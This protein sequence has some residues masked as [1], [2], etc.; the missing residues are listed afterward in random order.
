V[1]P[2][3][4]KCFCGDCVEAAGTARRASNTFSMD[5][6]FVAATNEIAELRKENEQLRQMIAELTAKVKWYEEQFRLAQQYRFGASSERSDPDQPRL[7]NE[8]EVIADP[9]LPEPAVENIIYERRK[10]KGRREAMLANLPVETVE[11]RLSEE[12]QVCP[13]CGGPMHEMR[14]ETREELKVIPAQVKL[15]RHKRQVYAC[16]NCQ[17]NEERTP[18]ATA[19]MPNPV[20]KNSLASSSAVAYIMDQKYGNGMPLYRLEQ[21]LERIG[22]KLSR[23]TMANW[24]IYSSEHW[25]E[26]MYERMH[27]LLK[28]HDVLHADETTVQVLHEPGRDPESK[29]YMWVYLTGRYDSPIVLYDYQETRAG[30]HPKDFLSGFAG[31]LHVDGYSGYHGIPGVT[32]AGCWAHERRKWDEALKAL[33]TQ[34][35]GAP[36][37]AKEGLEFC[38]RLFAIESDLQDASPDERYQAR[39]KR[40]RPVLDAFLAWLHDQE[41][42]ALPKSALG[43]A[44]A[45]S[46]SQ[47]DNLES[48]M[49]DGR[50]EIS[51]NRAERAIKPFVIGR[52][53]WLF[54]NTPQGARASA[55]IY[56]IVET[57]KQNKLNPFAYLCYLFE[58]MPNIDIK[59]LASID[60]LLPFSPSLPNACRTGR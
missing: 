30:C 8:A 34:N 18:I 4:Q 1:K 46:L 3:A 5:D 36:V 14:V 27:D 53:N 15:V 47:W 44:V 49:L 32:L 55:M 13:Q 20:I 25:L 37:A 31:Y 41:P 24:M 39:L 33:P 58:R 52:K 42:K 23:Q 43:Q 35:R 6:A 38:N 2:E 21:Q 51:N 54:N 28:G 10:Q 26:P 17:R 59:D 50:L 16:R 56:S 60:E 48:F 12:E 40:S 9:L 19:P 57:A 45:Y 29:S 22:V 7:F 11:Y